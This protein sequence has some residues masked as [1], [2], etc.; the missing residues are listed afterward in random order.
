MS[1]YWEEPYVEPEIFDVIFADAFNNLKESLNGAAL[2]YINDNAKKLEQAEES[3]KR[4]L[5]DNAELRKQITNEETIRAQIK[6]ELITATMGDVRPGDTVWLIRSEN[7]YKKCHVCNGTRKVKA[8]MEGGV[9]VTATCPNCEYKGIKVR[10]KRYAY[11]QTIGDITHTLD[12]NGNGKLRYC[13][14]SNWF[15][16]GEKNSVVLYSQFG[17]GEA[18]RT[19]KDTENEIIRLESLNEVI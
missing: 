19:K 9:E 6:E 15:S 18:Y 16:A 13:I 7:I 1:S 3:I 8:V 5:A 12:R 14:S 2:N 17:E 4:L 10:T 11:P